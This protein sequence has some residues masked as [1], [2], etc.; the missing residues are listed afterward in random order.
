MKLLV[1]S[2]KSS[3]TADTAEGDYVAVPRTAS[4]RERVVVRIRRL[5]FGACGLWFSGLGAGLLGAP[6]GVEVGLELAAFAFLGWGLGIARSFLNRSFLNQPQVNVV[7]E[8]I[9]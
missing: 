1:N 8:I 7:F 5:T 9:S 3:P 6:L 2:S 4:P